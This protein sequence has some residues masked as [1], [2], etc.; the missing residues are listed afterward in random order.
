MSP[1]RKAI[2][3]QATL[4][5]CVGKEPPAP[6]SPFWI[7]GEDDVKRPSNVEAL[8][9]VLKGQFGARIEKL[10]YERGHKSMY[11]LLLGLYEAGF[12]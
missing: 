10:K 6:E 3:T 9:A 12:R 1:S 8:E 4:Q 5:M 7:P 11:G 2:D